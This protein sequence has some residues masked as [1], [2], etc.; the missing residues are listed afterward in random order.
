MNI[1][2][3]INEDEKNIRIRLHYNIYTGIKSI[4][5]NDEKVST[6]FDFFGRKKL[7]FFISEKEYTIKLTP[8]GYGYKGELLN[9]QESIAAFV[10]NKEKLIIPLWVIPFAIINMSITILS[11]E[12][13]TTW[14]IGGVA[15]FATAELAKRKRI[16]L[17]I[18]IILAFTISALAWLMYYKFYTSVSSK[19]PSDFLPFM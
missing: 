1:L 8:E 10:E 13:V 7:S 16:N 12:A 17:A 2:W 3:N 4:F 9:G 5:V 6:C 14:L 18:R 11:V 19:A 15:T